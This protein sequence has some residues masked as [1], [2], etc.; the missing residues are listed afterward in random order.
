MYKEDKQSCTAF[1]Q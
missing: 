1:N